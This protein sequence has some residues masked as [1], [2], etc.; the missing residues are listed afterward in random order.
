M[1]H[2]QQIALMKAAEMPASDYK[3]QFLLKNGKIVAV[4]NLEEV[5]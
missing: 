3:R 1:E 5:G 4:V 2:E